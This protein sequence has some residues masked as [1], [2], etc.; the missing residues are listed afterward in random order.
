MDPL[1]LLAR[2][3]NTLAIFST[4]NSD[5]FHDSDRVTKPESKKTIILMERELIL[6]I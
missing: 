6:I 1:L 5:G 4:F 3:S 2:F